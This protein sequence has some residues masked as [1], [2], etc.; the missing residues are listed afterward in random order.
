MADLEQTDL[1]IPELS[2]LGGPLHRLGC[3]LGL[4]REKTHTVRLGLAIGLFTWSI[5][6]LLALLEQSGPR[7]FSL[8]V[9]G[10]DVRLLVAIPL[11]FL[12]ETWA[13]PQMAEFA[14]YIVRSG[15]VRRASFP[16]LAVDIRRLDRLK[17]S[18]LAEALFLLAAFA[19]P[20]I[21]PAGSLPGRT[22]NWASIFHSSGGSHIW[23]D[24]WYLWFCLP[25]FRFLMLRWLWRLSLWWYFLWRVEKLEL[26][27]IPT[28]SDGAAGL[29]YL[30][31]VHETFTPLVAAISAVFAAGFAEDISSGTTTFESLYSSIPMVLLVTL[32][33]F[34]GPLC[35]FSPKL[36]VCRW[37][38]MSEYMGMASR[39][40][41]AFDNKWIR[42]KEATGESQL[43]TADLQSLADLTNSVNV[44]R[45][46]QSIP[47]GRRLIVELA[48]FAMVPLLPLVFLKYPVH[49]VAAQ[50]FHILT[51]L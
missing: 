13:M 49:Q 21:V 40:V 46:M 42:D 9:I 37:T 39:Y 36:Y 20:M 3:R 24:Y 47:F 38:G 35:M 34:V 45:Q 14:R 10:V 19:L 31:T 6:T 12:C 41:S 51:G 18:W 32:A 25:L 44:V 23:T 27:L 50:L 48:V 26:R 8:A 11:L 4:V 15:V 22:A 1:A 5:L 16:V 33:V 17:D 29:G 30:E 7:M 2:L 28:H 43:G